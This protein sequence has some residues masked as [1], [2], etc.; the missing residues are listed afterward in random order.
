MILVSINDN[1][2]DI[3][4]FTGIFV[5][6][7]SLYIVVDGA[8]G[9]VIKLKADLST[10]EHYHP[11]IYMNYQQVIEITSYKKLYLSREHMEHIMK[12]QAWLRIHVMYSRQKIT[13][14]Y[15]FFVP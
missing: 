9:C 6:D 10:I 1:V 2:E 11:P 13:S 5:D 7:T 4:T 14:T 15:L 3:N 12:A 8:L